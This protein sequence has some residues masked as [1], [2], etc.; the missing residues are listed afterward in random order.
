[1]KKEVNSL[2]RQQENRPPSAP[3]SFTPQ[4]P[5]EDDQQLLSGP[6]GFRGPFG[7]RI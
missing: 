4:L 6:T 2:N 3:P 1:M 5:R 7:G